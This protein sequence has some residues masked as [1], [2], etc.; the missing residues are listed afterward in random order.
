M[1]YQ[2]AA[3]QAE[4]GA[5]DKQQHDGCNSHCAAVLRKGMWGAILHRGGAQGPVVAVRV[6]QCRQG[7]L[8]SGLPSCRSRAALAS[9]HEDST[10][11]THCTVVVFMVARREA[12][13]FTLANT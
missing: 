7:D 13:R 10:S 6:Q 4:G 9:R 11:S 12:R 1:T 8:Q 2:N 3:L 5:H